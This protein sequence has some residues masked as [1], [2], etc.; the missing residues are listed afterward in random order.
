MANED[1]ND[2][3]K[4]VC[5]IQ[6]AVPCPLRILMHLRRKQLKE[7]EVRCPLGCCALSAL[8]SGAP[9]QKTA[10]RTRREMATDGTNDVVQVVCGIQAASPCPL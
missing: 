5:G 9:A 4:V 6:A 3:V 1:A 2:V 8:S 7:Q 10:D